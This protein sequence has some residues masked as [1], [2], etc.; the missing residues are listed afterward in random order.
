MFSLL[1]VEN[2]GLEVVQILQ[3]HRLLLMVMVEGELEHMEEGL[4]LLLLKV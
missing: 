2:E 3:K 1:E 4:N